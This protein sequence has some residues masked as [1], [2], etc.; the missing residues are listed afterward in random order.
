MTKIKERE[1][2]FRIW[3]ADRKEFFFIDLKNFPINANLY[4]QLLEKNPIQQFTGL[5]DI[6]GK[7]I[8][9]GDI[10]ETVYKTKGEIVF[11]DER[12]AKEYKFGGIGSFS[13]FIIREGLRNYRSISTVLKVIGNIYENPEL[14]SE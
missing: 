6:N 9:E 3:L 2:R 5:K 14:L 10:V 12:Y 13:E 7:D 8:Y 11:Y 1:I 4:A